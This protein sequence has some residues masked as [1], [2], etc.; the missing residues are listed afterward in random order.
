MNLNHRH[1]CL[2]IL[3]VAFLASACTILP[4][5]RHYD[6]YRLPPSTIAAGTGTPLDM[7]LRIARPASSDQ[8]GGSQIAVIPDGHRMIVYQGARWSSPVPSLWRDHLLDAFQN[9]GRVRDLSSDTEIL[10]ADVE[11]GGLLRAFQ[12]EYR[13][14][15]PKVVVRL[16]AH[17]VDIASR[18][19]LATRRFETVEPVRGEQV[20]EVVDAFGRASDR[21]AVDIIEWTIREAGQ[22][23]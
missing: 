8:L 5:P 2:L 20:A 23:E 12:T 21:L 16:D 6:V 18:R 10:R 19:I 11:L 4:E 15:N 7:S 3:C 22:R 1:G 17:L 14:G 9:D 13:N